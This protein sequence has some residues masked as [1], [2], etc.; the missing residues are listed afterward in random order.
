MLLKKG[1]RDL[2]SD[3]FFALLRLSVADNLS[4]LSKNNKKKKDYQKNYVKY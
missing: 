3:A 1:A 2:K 4:F